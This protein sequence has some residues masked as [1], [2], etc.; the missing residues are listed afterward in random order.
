[1]NTPTVQSMQTPDDHRAVRHVR[2]RL[3]DPLY[4]QL[5]HRMVELGPS[6]SISDLIVELVEIGLSMSA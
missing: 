1:M 5:K 4:K 6:A 2:L 3:P